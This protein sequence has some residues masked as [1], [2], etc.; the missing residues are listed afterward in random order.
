MK[1]KAIFFDLYGTVAF[2]EKP[3]SGRFVSDF[4]VSRG[5]EIYPQALDAAWHYVSFV[6]YPKFGFESWDAWLRQICNRLGVDVD[7]K[8]IEEWSSFYKNENWQLYPDVPDAFNMVKKLGL[9]TA[10]VTSIAKFMYIKALKPILDK[11]DLLVDA[12][13]FHSE[14]SNPKIY[15]EILKNL[16]IKPEQAIMI[17][18]EEDVDILLPKRLGMRAIF[19]DRAGKAQKILFEVEPDAIVTNLLEAIQI[20]E[21]WIIHGG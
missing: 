2:L 20:V 9:K 5:Y 6:D 4:L 10:I 18:D 19:L 3:L 21:N 11:L 16:K 17:G 15:Q 13:T 7:D 8:T 12:F 1:L 14:K